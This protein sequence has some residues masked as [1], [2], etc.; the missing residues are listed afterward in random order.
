MTPRARPAFVARS[1]KTSSPDYEPSYDVAGA[2]V[3]DDHAHAAELVSDIPGWLR[4]EDALKLYELAFY[5][6]GPI[7]EIG[8]SRGKSGTLMAMATRDAGAATIVVS[9]DIDPVAGT[10]AVAAATA[11]GVGDRLLAFR[12]SAAAFFAVNPTFA[13]SLTF[14]DGDHSR[15]GVRRDLRTLEPHVPVGGLV[16]LHDYLDPRNEDPAEPAYG[17]V[18]AVAASWL[19]AQ[20]DFAGVF[21]ACA[22][23]RRARGGPPRAGVG[24]FDVLRYDDAR[25]QYRQR[26]RHPLAAAARRATRL[27]RRPVVRRP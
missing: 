1:S 15:Q 13:P 9:V 4:P 27:L 26:V 12:G 22:L 24:T 25:L 3:G 11:K 8:T 16:L 21:G 2:C 14:V 23:F 19:P 18:A 6:T 20:A 10:A 17:V 7:L 5:A